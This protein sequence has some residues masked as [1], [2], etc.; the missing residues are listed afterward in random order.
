M[1]IGIDAIKKLKENGGLTLR[2]GEE[3]TY[4][5]GYQVADYGEQAHN[6]EDALKLVEKYKG[7]CG[8]WLEKGVYYV[9]HSF[10]VKTKKEALEIGRKHK[11]IS[12]LKWK[13]MSLVY[14]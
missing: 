9:D 12:V 5:T 7:D 2:D 8:V 3:I 11:Q 13:D 14:C 10:R 1:M 6:A 4:K